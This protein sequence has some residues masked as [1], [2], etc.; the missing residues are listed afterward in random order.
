MA[1]IVTVSPSHISDVYALASRLRKQDEVEIAAFGL[2][3]KRGLRL[4]FRM[5]ILRKTYFVDGE[6]AA[7]SGMTG[8][9]LSDTGHPYL[10]TGPAV[11]RAPFAVLREAKR[12]VDEMMM[13]RKTLSGEVLASYAKAVRMLEMMGFEIGEPRAIGIHGELFSQFRK[14]R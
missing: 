6:I 8:D 13:L 5:G 7:M 14:E 10:L 9:L 11:E 2:S 3:A 1:A 12:S 4:C